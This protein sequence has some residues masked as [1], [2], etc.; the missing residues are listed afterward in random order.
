MSEERKALKAARE[1]LEDETGLYVGSAY[2]YSDDSHRIAEEFLIVYSDD[3]QVVFPE[4]FEGF[5][6]VRR[7][8]PRA[9]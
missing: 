8:M 3:K 1:R 4:T 6:V 2:G 7:S 5:K 9:L